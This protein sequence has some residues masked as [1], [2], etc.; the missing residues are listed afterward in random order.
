[1]NQFKTGQIVEIRKRFWRIDS[2]YKNELT[3]TS[4]D[5]INNFQKRFYAPL[6]DI[7]LADTKLPSFDKIGE[8]SKQKLLINAYRISLIHG[9]SPLLSLQ[10]STVIP[11][12][13]QL[14]PVVMALNS[15]RV[16]LLIA[17]DVGLGKTIEAG[18]IINELIARQLVRR[19]L[20]ICPANLREQWQEALSIFFKLDFEIISS[21]HR[22]YLEKSLPIGLSPWEYFP[23]LITSVDYAKTKV[24]KNEILN[25]DWD[26]ILIDEAHLCAR[27]HLSSD[28]SI[29]MQ[30]WELLKAVYPKTKHLLLLTATPHN[31]Y[32]DSFSSLIKALDI[33]ATSGKMVS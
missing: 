12:N 15:P 29:T 25:H 9:S 11:V 10:R 21:L 3:A 23:K 14:V 20:I 19:I 8:L 6:E 22:K 26:L 30:R 28:Y 4:I 17:D 32:T 33:Q 1:M 16:R 27:P 2:I 5:S 31:G 13:F 7:K 24:N 18:L